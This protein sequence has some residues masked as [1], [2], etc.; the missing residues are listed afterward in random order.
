MMG[1][2]QASGSVVALQRYPV[3]SMM[4]EALNAVEVTRSKKYFGI[5]SAGRAQPQRRPAGPSR[6]SRSVCWPSALELALLRARVT[7]ARL[8]NAA[9]FR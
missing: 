2:A 3:K 1:S 8:V 5:R 7:T 6:S 4:G 9:K